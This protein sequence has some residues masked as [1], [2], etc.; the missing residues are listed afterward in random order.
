MFLFGPIITKCREKLTLHHQHHFFAEI[1][2]WWSKSKVVDCAQESQNVWPT[3]NKCHHTTQTRHLFWKFSRETSTKRCCDVR[4]QRKNSCPEGILI[5]ISLV[6]GV[7]KVLV[8]ILLMDSILIDCQQQLKG[9]SLLVPHTPVTLLGALAHTC[10]YGFFDVC[11][12]RFIGLL[13]E[14]R[15]WEMPKTALQTCLPSS[16]G[17]ALAF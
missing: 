14:L 12:L 4:Q 10:T 6:S 17:R 15:Q 7:C 8:L 16:V 1:D 2:N 3:R 9:M 5:K 11:F 13:A